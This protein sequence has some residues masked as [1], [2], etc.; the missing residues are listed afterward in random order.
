MLYKDMIQNRAEA[1]YFP[2]FKTKKSSRRWYQ[3]DIDTIIYSDLFRKMQ[4]KSQ[5]LSI[6][7]PVSRSRLIHTFEVVRIAKEISEKLGLNTELTEAI[8]L[9]HDLGNVAYGKCADIFLQNQTSKFFKHEEVSELM[10]KVC[11]SR[12]IPDKYREQ[13]RKAIATDSSVTHLISIPEFPY[14][15]EVYQQKT[16]IYYICISPEVLDGVKKHGT[17]LCAY[18]LEGQVVNY[19]D[20]IAY[21][22][23]DI[24]DFEV[25]GIFDRQTKERYERHLDDLDGEDTNK[26]FPI[27][28]IVGKTTSIRTATLIERFVSDNKKA[29]VEETLPTIPSPFFSEKIPQLQKSSLLGQAIDR[30]WAFKKEFYENDLI[31]ISNITSTSKMEQLW[32]ILKKDSAFVDNNRSYISFLSTLSSPIFTS[33]RKE[34][35]IIDEKTWEEWKKSYFIAH[36][37][38]D[39]IDLI[40]KSFLERD[41]EFHLAL[42][43]NK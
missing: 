7:D 37:S 9:A 24:N 33:Y 14:Q 8:A 41:Y 43:K 39:E 31:K 5:L 19:A 42:P 10:L 22:I 3:H 26:H 12:P 34:K 6:H 11:S 18:T 36:L 29:L 21:L 32:D 4:R 20:N 2:D 16:S 27:T 23:Q 30:C 35:D 38:C 28:G 40:I 1:L 25:A 15:L 17:D 13:A